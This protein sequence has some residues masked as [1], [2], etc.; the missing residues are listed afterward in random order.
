[1]NTITIHPATTEDLA[2]LVPLF[3]AYR[4]FY[5][6]PSDPTRTFEFLRERLSR[7]DSTVLLARD[8]QARDLGFAQ[9]Y[10]TFSSLRCTRTWILNDLYV[11]AGARGRGF[12]T[13]LIDHAIQL[14]RAQGVDSIILETA[15]SNRP[16][17]QLYERMGFIRNTEFL[18]YTLRP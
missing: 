13:G 7:Q 4:G 1:M 16:A 10:P 11:V 6:Q 18:T 15:S 5:G 12:A 17:R 2:R 9:L 3:E 8:E 14:A